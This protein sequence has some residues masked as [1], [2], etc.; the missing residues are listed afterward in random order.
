MHTLTL[1]TYENNNKRFYFNKINKHCYPADNVCKSD[2]FAIVLACWSFA[3]WWRG[4]ADFVI[5]LH[6]KTDEKNSTYVKIHEH[7]ELSFRRIGYL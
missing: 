2:S 1:I 4:G 7:N 6:K 5:N 3:I